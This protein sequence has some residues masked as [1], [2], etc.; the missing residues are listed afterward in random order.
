MQSFC[1]P[2]NNRCFN[3]ILNLD[4]KFINIHSMNHPNCIDQ[5]L[6]LAKLLV[7]DGDLGRSQRLFA[8]LMGCVALS[9]SVLRGAGGCKLAFARGLTHKVRVF[10]SEAFK[11]EAPGLTLVLREACAREEG[12]K[13][14]PLQEARRK[15]G[16]K[17]GLVLRGM[18]ESLPAGRGS[19]KLLS[20]TGDELVAWATREFAIPTQSAWVKGP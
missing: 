13:A 5:D 14:V 3:I 4:A 20:L 16:W 7:F 17:W 12:W 15:D 6:K 19:K 9:A 1:F 10:A 18:T 2:F 11:L 8:A